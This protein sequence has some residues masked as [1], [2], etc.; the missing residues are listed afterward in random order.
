MKTERHYD[1]HVGNEVF[2]SGTHVMAILNVTPDSFLQEVATRTM[3]SKR[4]KSSWSRVPKLSIS[5]VSPLA[6]ARKA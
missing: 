6:P 3:R 4:Q 1:F 2:E 5:A